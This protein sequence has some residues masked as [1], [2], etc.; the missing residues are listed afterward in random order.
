MPPTPPNHVN[1]Q[2]LTPQSQPKASN[3][4]P[5]HPSYLT[6]S[7]PPKSTQSHATNTTKPCKSTTTN[8]PY[9]TQT[10]QCSSHA[11]HLTSLSIYS[12]TS[13]TSF[14][15]YSSSACIFNSI[16]YT[17]NATPPTLLTAR[18]FKNSSSHSPTFEFCRHGCPRW[19]RRS[20]ALRAG[21]PPKVRPKSRRTQTSPSLG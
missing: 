13:Y 2:L 10:I 17:K 20:V 5:M 14:L 18:R 21:R 1:L 15:V 4:H 6:L 7:S 3:A 12:T 9:P 19:A 11:P 16:F 8:P